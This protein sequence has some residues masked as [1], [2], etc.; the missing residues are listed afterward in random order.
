M[1][2]FSMDPRNRV[3]AFM[4]ACC[5]A[6]NRKGVL[7]SKHH[8]C[9]LQLLGIIQFIGK[10]CPHT[11]KVPLFPVLF[12]TKVPPLSPGSL[13][14]SRESFTFCPFPTLL[15]HILSSYSGH[16]LSRKVKLLLGKQSASL[17]INC[18]CETLFQPLPRKTH[19]VQPR[20][21]VR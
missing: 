20:F 4:S 12:N 7:L 18:F 8:T 15:D 17:A 13:Q 5:N 9:S 10:H 16:L 2:T 1:V 6:V 11:S 21:K 14:L 19:I 3:T